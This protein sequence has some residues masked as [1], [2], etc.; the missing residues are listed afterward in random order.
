MQKQKQNTTVQWFAYNKYM[1][2]PHRL[3]IR[4]LFFSTRGMNEHP[5][6]LKLQ[7]KLKYYHSEIYT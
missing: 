3:E 1:Y 5:T 4:I 6:A 2:M 7:G